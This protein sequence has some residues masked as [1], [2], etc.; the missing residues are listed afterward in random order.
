MTCIR[1]KHLHVYAKK[2]KKVEEK[3][4][5]G[6]VGQRGRREEEGRGEVEGREREYEGERVWGKGGR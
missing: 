6:K 3:G 4:R 2:S 5:V 1:H